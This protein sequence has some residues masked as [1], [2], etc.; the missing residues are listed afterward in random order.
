[1]GL[2]KELKKA[3]KAK[4]ITLKELSKR[5]GVSIKT[6]YSMTAN[7]PSYI[8]SDTQEKIKK[9][10]ED[11]EGMIVLELTQEQ[12]ELLIEGLETA[13]RT[14]A[15]AFSFI[16]A[17]AQGADANHEDAKEFWKEANEIRQKINDLDDL[18]DNIRRVVWYNED[19][20][21]Y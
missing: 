15:G 18:A 12:A 8:R 1:M 3:C 2:G 20:E 21:D 5:S 4:G 6:I 10:L 17:R 16:Y 19:Q 7:D 11:K 9:A 14:Q 13:V